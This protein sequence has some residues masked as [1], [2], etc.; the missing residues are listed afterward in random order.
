MVVLHR[1][2]SVWLDFGLVLHL[3]WDLICLVVGLLPLWL[4]SG[5]CIVVFLVY[6]RYIS[7]VIL[8]CP[9]A[10]DQTPKLVELISYKP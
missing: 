10:K 7:C 4:M 1:V 2:E 3:F 6:F 8:T 5:I 9:L